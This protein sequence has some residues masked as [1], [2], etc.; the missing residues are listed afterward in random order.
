[1]K[2]EMKQ[3]IKKGATIL[4]GVALA[5]NT[6]VACGGDNGE[7]APKCVCPPEG[8]HF[9]TCEEYGCEV[10]GCEITEQA[11][12]QIATLT[13][14]FGEG[15]ST[16]VTGNFTDTQWASVA[17]KI[18]T[19]INAAFET[20]NPAVKNRFRTVFGALGINI[21]V[22]RTSEQDGWSKWKATNEN[23]DTLYLGFDE[24]DN[25]LQASVASA[26]TAIANGVPGMA[27]TK[28]SD[29]DVKK[30]ALNK[31]RLLF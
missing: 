19:A 29:P 28:G 1:M 13:N 8:E 2:N 18:Q 22:V 25:D 12:D 5:A 27:R 26:V 4:A 16:T 10:G 9:L 20:G 24:L 11:K 17:G 3:K 6:F 7:T 31:I 15:L 23:W 30:Y 21:E 14:L